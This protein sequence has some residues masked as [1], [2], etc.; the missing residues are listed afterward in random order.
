MHSLHRSSVRVVVVAVFLTAA[1]L[2]ANACS[3]KTAQ[4]GTASGDGGTGTTD[5]SAG[6]R[7]NPDCPASDP[8]DGASCTKDGLLCEYGDDYNPLCNVVRVCSIK[9]WARPLFYGNQPKCPTTA[10]TVP[11]N[12]AECPATR[13]AVPAGSACTKTSD[14]GAAKCAYDGASCSCGVFCPSYPVSP[15][16][17]DPDAGRTDYCCDRSKVQW[18]CFDGPAFCTTPR[19]RVGSACTIEGETCALAEPGEC[20]QPVLSCEKGVWTL[21][22][23][24]CPISTAR[25]K[26]EIAYVDADDTE[27]LH[28]QIMSTRLATYRYKSPAPAGMGGSDARHLGFIIEDMPE[29][30]AAVLPSRDRVDVYGYTSMTVASLQHQQRE[31]DALKAEVARL[32]DENAAMKRSMKR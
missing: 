12:P 27:R 21:P 32:R 3:G 22:N 29:G 9:R 11:P 1:G 18:H 10:P 4:D 7:N 24:S 23:V 20:G 17:C 25:A 5:G 26:R 6:R 15:P 2:A 30:S 14:A 31:I 28:A 8:G 16:D 19:S 13:A